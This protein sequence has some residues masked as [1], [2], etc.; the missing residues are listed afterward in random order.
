MKTTILTALAVAILSFTSFSQDKQECSAN[1]E[2]LQA[3]IKMLAEKL[4]DDEVVEQIEAAQ[5]ES[6]VEAK[7]EA[8]ERQKITLSDKHPNPYETEQ[9]LTFSIPKDAKEVQLVF[10]NNLGQTIKTVS[11]SERGE[12]TLKVYMSE[13]MLGNYAYSLV[14]DGSPQS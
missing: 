5:E 1:V 13:Y 11:V 7:L 14:V 4:G 9:D 8:V 12:T 10:S 2:A 6:I 3:Q